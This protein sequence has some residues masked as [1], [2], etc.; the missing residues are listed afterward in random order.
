MREYRPPV[1]AGFDAGLTAYLRSLL[2]ILRTDRRFVTTL[3]VA[4]LA[5]TT[6]GVFP[7]L[8]TYATRSRGLSTV[9]DVPLLIGAAPFLTIPFTLLFARLAKFIGPARIGGLLAL[10]TAAAVPLAWAL[11]GRWQ[12][13]P[14][15]MLMLGAGVYTYAL[16]TVMRS[17]VPG[18]MHQYL[19]LYFTACMIPG[20]TPLGLAW[21]LDRWPAVALGSI[22]LA[23]LAGG[24]GFFWS[25]RG[26][27]TGQPAPSP[28]EANPPL[29]AAPAAAQI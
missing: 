29:V 14:L 4:A 1:P 16:L 27:G 20:L 15:A 8:L 17:A 28:P 12:F 26:A 6:V 24:V 7:V 22:L 25:E 23:S 11:H 21:V 19:A 18:L 5:F 10:I 13:I 3:K 2:T 9:H